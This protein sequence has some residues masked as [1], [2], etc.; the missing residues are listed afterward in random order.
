MNSVGFSSQASTGRL[1]KPSHLS[2]E[3]LFNEIK[4]DVGQLTE[5]PLDLKIG[6]ARHQFLGSSFDKEINDFVAIFVKGKK[7]GQ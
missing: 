1:P 2:Y 5:T 3:G 6:Y 4:F 7:D